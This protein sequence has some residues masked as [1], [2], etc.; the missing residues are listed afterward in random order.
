MVVWYPQQQPD[1]VLDA[2]FQ[3]L[4]VVPTFQH[5]DEPVLRRFPVPHPRSTA[6]C[7]DI[8]AL[9]PAFRLADLA[10]GRQTPQR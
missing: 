2:F 10:H 4:Q 8:H 9:S 3:H 5:G 6:P 7:F 1:V